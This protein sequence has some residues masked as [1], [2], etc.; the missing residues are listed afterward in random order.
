MKKTLLASLLAVVAMNANAEL[1]QHTDQIAEIKFTGTTYELGKHVGEEGKE[2]IL[3]GIQRF[4]A[5]LGAM[6]EGMSVESLSETFK[7]NHVFANLKKTAPDSAAYIQG[8]SD[9]LNLR[10]KLPAIY[11]HE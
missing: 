7:K 11:W 8:L 5:T 3:A 6:L 1:I 10:S 9:A 4:D 2:Q